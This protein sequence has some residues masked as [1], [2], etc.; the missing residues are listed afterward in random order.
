MA[1]SSGTPSTPMRTANVQLT[2]RGRRL[3][4][5]FSV[6]DRSLQPNDLL[7]FYRSMSEGLMSL[8]VHEAKG[9]GHQ[10][11]CK[12]GCGACCRQLVPISPIEARHLMKVIESMPEPR[13]S[14]IRQRFADAREKLQA[15]G[16]MPRLGNPQDAPA[17]SPVKG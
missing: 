14:E 8:A 3:A 15:A 5:K 2:I 17:R 11:T 4:L 10:V 7:P 13:R 1:D 16:L 9:Q 6:P 12:A